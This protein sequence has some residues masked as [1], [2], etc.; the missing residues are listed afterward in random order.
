[1]NT[2]I[3]IS[4]RYT[5]TSDIIF[6][7]P[8]TS[9]LALFPLFSA[10]SPLQISPLSAMN[11]LTRNS[12]L[13]SLILLI[14]HTPLNTRTDYTLDERRLSDKL[15][16]NLKTYTINIISTFIGRCFHECWKFEKEHKKQTKPN[17]HIT[18][19]SVLSLA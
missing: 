13:T 2:L 3:P 17:K 10:S 8:K 5:T 1:M 11:Q 9:P 16:Y 6:F 12:Y 4:T 19:P 14:I 15:W 18:D 7:L